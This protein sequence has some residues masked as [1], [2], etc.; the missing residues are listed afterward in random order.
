MDNISN[1]TSS[2]SIAKELSK[3]NNKKSVISDKTINNYLKYL[4]N[5]FAFY[6]VRRYDI[7]GKK[8][9]SSQDKYYL[10]DPSFKYAI[11]GTKNMNYGRI[12][13]NIVAIELLR[14]GYELYVGVL[15]NK[16]IDFVAIKKDEKIYIQVSD[17]I[18]GAKTFEREVAP[19]LQIKDAYPKMVIARTYHDNYQYEGI[20]IVDISKWLSEYK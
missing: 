1:L 10:V 18:S 2:R 14:R 17:D 13:E 3:V 5:A 19:L 4:C 9:L 6:K 8:Y 11:I 16:E 7:Q 15:N 20:Q 12:Y